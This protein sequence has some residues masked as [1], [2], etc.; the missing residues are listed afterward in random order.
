VGWQ[1]RDWAKL[2]ERELGALYGGGSAPKPGRRSTVSHTLIWCGI[3]LVAALAGVYILSRPSTSPSVD[4]PTRVYGHSITFA[5]VP[6]VCTEIAYNTEAH[7]WVCNLIQ[8]NLA[9]LPVIEPVPYD[10]SC[11]DA[12]AD[13][14][15]GHW[16]CH[17]T[18]PFPPSELPS[19]LMYAPDD[20]PPLPAHGNA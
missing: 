3:V 9:H 12:V 16:V 13:Q 19:V 14:T 2:D 7:G 20:V 11:A 15:D 1:D 17:S 10:G 5:G 8:S 6:S 4:G 18:T